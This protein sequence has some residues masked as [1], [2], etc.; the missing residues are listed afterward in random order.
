MALSCKA[1]DSVDSY[2]WAKQSEKPFLVVRGTI[3]GA[4]SVPRPRAVDVAPPLPLTEGTVRIS[5]RS[6]TANGFDKTFDADVT[7]RLRCLSIWCPRTPDDGPF[8]LFL[9]RTSA[10]YVLELDPCSGHMIDALHPG[11]LMR[12]LACHTSGV[13]IKEFQ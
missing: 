4:A 7:L 10:G 3:D 13:C 1:P 12:L 6:L 5:G 9:E 2:E 11:Q 8:I